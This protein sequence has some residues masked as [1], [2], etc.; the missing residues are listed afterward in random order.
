[1]R[2][3]LTINANHSKDNLYFT[4]LAPITY[5]SNQFSALRHRIAEPL[6]PYENFQQLKI[7]RV[8][9][10]E[11]KTSDKNAPSTKHFVPQQPL[12]Y[13]KL[14]GKWLAQAGF[15]ASTRCLV[16]VYQGMLVIT[17]DEAIK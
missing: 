1:M 2:T 16:E 7:A 11:P 10:T 9:Q 12:P 14:Q 6:R 5:V 17:P 8:K 13:L 4:S 15:S 3:S